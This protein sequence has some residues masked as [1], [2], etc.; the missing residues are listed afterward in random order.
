MKS[1]LF[2]LIDQG[3]K[4]CNVGLSTGM[5]KLELY[6]DS[7]LPGTSYLVGAQSGVGKSTYTLFTFIYK[8]LMDWLNTED[9]AKKSR[10]PYWIFFNLEMT[11][12]QIQGKLL[13][14][15]IYEMYGEQI[16]FKEM[17]SR[18]RETMLSDEHYDLI[19]QCEKFLD[20]LDERIKFHDG[21]FNSDKYKN[22]LNED[23]KAF[24]TFNNGEF[25]PNNPNQIIGVIVDHLSLTRASNGRS[26]KEEM[27]LV[28]SYGVQYRNK[29]GI[30]SPIMIMQFNR[31]ANGGE[32]IKAHQQEPDYSDFKDSGSVVEDSMVVLAL[33]N[34][35][36]FKLTSYRGY[37]ITQLGQNFISVILLKSRFG[38]SDIVDC[39]GF[40]GDCSHYKE[41][42]KANE[43]T[44]YEKYKDPSW[45]LQPIKTDTASDT[46]SKKSITLTL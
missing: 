20:L 19:K 36:K 7:Y 21:A 13:S 18:G 32:R 44:D 10:D 24:G 29:C 8:P 2:D 9:E 31:N 45:T 35:I 34:P 38:T 14:M 11:P 1:R 41:L 39:L 16:R 26:K 30:V 3:R 37:D 42:P 4:G 40:Y 5:D 6:M 23:L 12:E 27:D 46:S 33:H 43:I 22:C 28:S 17:F 25:T 15:Y